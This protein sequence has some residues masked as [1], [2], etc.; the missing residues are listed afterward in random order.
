MKLII[1]G[2]KRVNIMKQK[3]IKISLIGIFALGASFYMGKSDVKAAD[4]CVNMCQAQQ[5]PAQQACLNLCKSSQGHESPSSLTESWNSPK[6]VVTEYGSKSL[7]VDE[8]NVVKSGAA[9]G[10][11]LAVGTPS[12]AS[13]SSGASG[14]TL[15]SNILDAK[16]NKGKEEEK[17]EKEQ[18]MA[19][20]K[21]VRDQKS[22]PEGIEHAI[23][24]EFEKEKGEKHILDALTQQTKDA[25]E[26]KQDEK[27]ED[28]LHKGKST[29]NTRAHKD[30]SEYFETKDDKEP[31]CSVEEVFTL[32]VDG[33]WRQAI[34]QA[35]E[36]YN[37]LG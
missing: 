15:G 25:N 2:P 10:V 8:Q 33:L 4:L 34:S 1:H 16:D 3:Q 11:P 6:A 18:G 36:C 24:K 32:L 19:S 7:S 29:D 23:S 26:R 14:Q 22:I 20:K 27:K 31:R 21:I 5:G 12:P 28:V 9:Q 13:A 17:R 35:N 37:P 30:I